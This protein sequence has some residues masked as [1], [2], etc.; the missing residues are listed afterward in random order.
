S[1]TCGS[2]IDTIFDQIKEFRPKV[3]SVVNESK[4]LEL[5][6]RLKAEGIEIAEAAAVLV[7]FRQIPHY[8]PVAPEIYIILRPFILIGNPYKKRR[9]DAFAGL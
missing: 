1:L 7:G 6:S 3:C 2:D 5:S 4:A 9:P 8:I